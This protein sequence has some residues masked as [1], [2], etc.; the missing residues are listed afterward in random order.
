MNN[1]ITIMNFA[2][3]V[4]PYIFNN[5]EKYIKWGSENNTADEYLKLYENVAEH[6]SSINF[7]LTNLIKND[8][9]E[10]EYWTLQKIALDYL[11]FGG[12]SVEVIKTRGNGYKINYLDISKLYESNIIDNSEICAF[13]SNLRIILIIRL[14]IFDGETF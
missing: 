3:E 5:N 11:I 4:I 6:N 9:Q 1:K 7:I 8:I 13:C 14:H 10:I 2:K 12:F